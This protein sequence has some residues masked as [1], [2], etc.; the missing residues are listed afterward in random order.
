MEPYL[1]ECLESVINQTERNLEIICVEDASTDDSL[2]ILEQYSKKDSR[3][4]VVKHKYNKGLCK[5]RKDA[6]EIAQGEYIMFLD[7]DDTLELCAC[8]KLYQAIKY[9]NVDFLQF[10]TNL[11]PNKD[12]SKELEQWT[13]NFLVPSTELLRNENLV[14]AC[15]IEHKFNCNL[16][17]KIWK[18]SICKK[19]YD[20][21]KDDYC[22][23][24]E[25]RYAMFIL[26]YYSNSYI[27]IEKHYYNYRIGVGVTGGDNIDLY[28]FETRCKSAFLVKNIDEFLNK[29][30][31][32]KDYEYEYTMFSN[33]IL[34]D[35][36][37]C[38]YK[39]LSSE[40]SGAGFDIL[41]TY[42]KP[43]NI[44]SSIARM[45]FEENNNISQR[46]QG[47][48]YISNSTVGIYYR[49]LGYQPMDSYIKNQIEVL[50]ANNTN[51]VLLTDEDAPAVTGTFNLDVPMIILPSSK[52]SNWD[53]YEHRGHVFSKVISSY[54]IKQV[55]YASPT[56]HIAW[57]DTLL[58]KMMQVSVFYMNEEA[59]LK[60]MEQLSNMNIE[61][62]EMK[63]AHIKLLESKTYRVGNAV[64]WIPR[65]ICRKL[66][67]G[68]NK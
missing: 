37:D 65:K 43:E 34:N 3:I 13:T 59:E 24:A 6:V 36:V 4:I 57:I 29:E 64:T 40:E 52:E 39:K 58:L 11:I 63:K 33:D 14:S 31:I 41:L 35:C 23:S 60:R 22:V 7:S 21:L 56:S 30:N 53:Q 2:E 9:Y 42:W 18:A 44:I 48:K 27:G 54:D 66:F 47:A 51:I 8:E 28:R 67:K 15:F 17:N 12:I 62:D 32:K 1:A 46:I 50:K 19:A 20:K 55:F 61:Y 49:Y 26:T 45:Y 68:E 38:W 16:W 5:T 25:D 10:G